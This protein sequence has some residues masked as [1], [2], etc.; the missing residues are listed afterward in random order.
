MRQRPLKPLGVSPEGRLAY[1]FGPFRLDAK[2]KVLLKGGDPVHLGRKPVEILLVLAASGGQVVTKDELLRTVWP[3]RVV[4]EAN[5]T[6]NI[7]LARKALDAER[8]EPGYIETFSGRGYRM[9]GPVTAQGGLSSRTEAEPA[10]P[11]RRAAYVVFGVAVAV[12]AAVVYW[13]RR[14]ADVGALSVLPVTRFTGK[15]FQ[16]SI[17]QAGDIT[18]LWEKSAT[19][20]PQVWVLR[21][22]E[23]TPRRISSG[24][25]T[26]SSP[27]WSPDGSRIAFLKFAESRGEIVIADGAG[28]SERK[29]A[30]VHHT[31]HGLAYRHLDWSPDGKWLA[32]DDSV[33]SGHP[34][35]IFLIPVETG[36]RRRLSQ[37]EDFSIGDVAPRFSPD[38]RTVSF[39][40]V[41]HRANQEVYTVPAAG[42]AVRKI[43]A[44][45]RQVSDHGWMKDGSLVIASNRGGE[46]RLWKAPAH[47]SEPW[48]GIRPTGVY[49]DF[50]IQF[51]L[52]TETGDLV[53]AV[54]QHDLNIWRLTLD[55]NTAEIDRWKRIVASTGQDV[56][57]QYSPD[58][59][60]ICFRSDRTGQE[61][62]WVSAADGSVQEQVTKGEVRP[63]VG[64]WSPD[65]GS[66]VF[67]D[68]RSGD[69][70]VASDRGGGT[71]KVSP[72]GAKGYHPVY[73]ADGRSFY[74]GTMTSIVRVPAAG[75]AQEAVLDMRGISLGLSTDGRS[76][77]FVRDATD[78]S[79]WRLDIESRHAGKALDG[80]VP[81]CSSCWD[82]TP[83]GIY[84]L[85]IKAGQSQ[86][87]AVFF[88]EFSTGVKRLVVEYPENMLP[89]GSGPFSL[90]R[91]ARFLLT[92]RVD[93]SNTDIM[94]VERFQ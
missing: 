48:R 22:G 69:I 4:D 59:S 56:S 23:T 62:L 53:Y 81:Y 13:P 17:S 42:G 78:S 25:A 18:F 46:F 64:R 11:K 37:P 92:V 38:G 57:P 87:H 27:V 33:H 89:I 26:C 71:W 63:S 3:D 34:L 66:I 93:P 43:T 35:A 40:R 44:D 6:Q 68:S 72:A 82:E 50:P 5:L 41:L 70:Y 75:G 73:S 14:T 19:E 16:P 91:D 83:S 15:E 61:Q 10:P 94:R 85:G 9:V 51:S 8:G 24:T 58:G 80:L 1:L 12:S 67:N 31:R 77:Y 45:S 39:I 47:Q 32:V 54:L 49:G 88:H 21:A 7:A 55:R 52:R 76:L 28:A 79:L 74:A 60:R 65:G 29:L 84:Y 90:S 36:E 30:D 2:A 86:Q 20:A